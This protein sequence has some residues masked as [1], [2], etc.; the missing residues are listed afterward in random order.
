MRVMA[1]GCCHLLG[2]VIAVTSAAPCA[3]DTPSGTAAEVA[4]APPK[5]NRLE[6]ARKRFQQ[7][8]S[9]YTYYGAGKSAELS[10]YDVA[11]LH[12][13]RVRKED[14]R[15]LSELGVVTVGYLTIGEDDRLQEGNGTGPG[16]KASWYFDGNQDGQPDQD[17]IWKSWYANTNDPLWRSSRVAEARRLIDDYGFDGVFLDLISVSEMYPECRGG[18]IQMMRDLRAALPDG[19][20]IMNQGFDIVADVASLAD[21]FMIESF[22]ATYDFENK[23][24]TLNDLSALDTHLNRVEKRLNPAIGKLPLRV[25]VLDYAEA[26][27]RATLEFAANRAASLGYLFSASPILLDDVYADVPQGE[28]DPKWLQRYVTPEKLAW[29]LPDARN[30]FPAGTIATPSSNFGGYTVEP[31]FDSA[32]DRSQHHWSKAAWAS[33]EDGAAPWLSLTFSEPQ[34]GGTLAITWHDAAGPSREFRVEVRAGEKDKWRD[35]DIRHNN[36]RRTT[37]HPLPKQA[38]RELRITQPPDGGSAGRPNLMWITRLEL[39]H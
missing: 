16:G 5:V 24:Y 31:M 35:A 14:V 22:T 21:G 32:T 20:I 37:V 28:A 25:L 18:M 34:Q 17:P 1:G 7:A 23:R 12:T 4:F 9:F 30:G 19:V 39:S 29:T 15:R 27:D 8:K 38:F 3:A 6:P 13:A 2:L 11:I 26:G 10:H 36:R 33:G